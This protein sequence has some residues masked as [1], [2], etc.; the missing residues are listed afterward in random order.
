[1][2]YLCMK[3]RALK[4]ILIYWC[5]TLFQHKGPL[6]QCCSTFGWCGTSNKYCDIFCDK[7]FNLK[8]CK[9]NLS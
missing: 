6:K 4:H 2:I 3:K 5:G 1:M 8:R 7:S 9:F